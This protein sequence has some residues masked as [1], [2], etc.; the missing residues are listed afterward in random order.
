MGNTPTP[1]GTSANTG[2]TLQG[3]ASYG[4]GCV[5]LGFDGYMLASMTTGVIQSQVRTNA[6]SSTDTINGGIARPSTQANVT[7]ANSANVST[8]AVSVTAVP[9]AVGYAWFW[10]A[11]AANLTL[12]AITT[13]NS[14]SITAN[15]AGTGSGYGTANFAALTAT[16][17]S[18]VSLDF[19]GLLTIG[20]QSALGSYQGVLATGTAGVGSTLTATG[21]GGVVEIETALKSFWDNYRLA[22]DTLWVNSQQ[23]KDISS[24]V[25]TTTSSA[26]NAQRIVFQAEP[27]KV[28]G[29]AV[30]VKEYLNKYA[31]DGST[32]L[33]IRLHP[34]MPPGTMMFTTNRL[35]YPLSDVTNVMQMR[36][37]RE[38]Y[39]IEWPITKRRYE[40]GVYE[41]GVLQHYFPPSMG[42][43]TNIAAG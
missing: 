37:R 19:D 27:G 40:Y 4:I 29:G 2:G 39:Q 9:G 22:P 14:V 35:P 43:V 12:G 32:V 31:M 8:M 7:T 21:D 42:V 17:N 3:N 18:K 25:A 41:D 26:P 28:M 11:A 1:S 36:M 23:M 34:N 5:A 13:I 10:G 16:D 30:V 15:A 6:D 24:K 33:K 20:S 38:Y